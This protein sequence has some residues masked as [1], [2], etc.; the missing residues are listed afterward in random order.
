MPFSTRTTYFNTSSNDCTSKISRFW[1]KIVII[2]CNFGQWTSFW[3]SSRRHASH[4]VKSKVGRLADVCR[5]YANVWLDVVLC[6]FVVLMNSDI[7]QTFVRLQTACVKYL[8]T[9]IGHLSGF[10]QLIIALLSDICQKK[11]VYSSIYI[12]I[13]LLTNY[14]PSC[15]SS[16]AFI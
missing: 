11:V 14:A 12:S 2:A 1:T 5:T 4:S 10:C 13:V 3:R 7:I 15:T 8:P 6:P 16:E 9:V